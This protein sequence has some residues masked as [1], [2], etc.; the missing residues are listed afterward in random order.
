MKPQFEQRLAQYRFSLTQQQADAAVIFSLDN[1][2]YLFN[3]S[4]EAAY[5]VVTQ[6]ALYLITDYRFLEQAQE[7]CCLLELPTKVICRDRD[8]Q[9]LGQAIAEVLQQEQAK[10]VLYEA[11]HCTVAQW[12]AI[13]ADN[14]KTQFSPSQASLEQL[15][16]RKDA[17]E[18]AQIRQAAQ[19]ADA[20]L[21]SIMPLF[22]LGVSERDLAL[23]LD[24][25]MQKRG[26]HGVSFET[27]LGFGGRSALPHCIP[28]ERRLQQGDLVVLDF[29]AVVNGYRSDMTRSFVAGRAN[30]QQRAMYDTVTKA[31]QNALA[32]LRDGVAAQVVNAAS[33]SVLQASS[34]ASYAG[35]GLGHGVGIKLH[36]QPFISSVCQEHLFAGYVV[37]IEP[38][39]YIPQVGGVRIEDDV[40]ITQDG[41]EF[42]THAPKQFELEM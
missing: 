21:A 2:R 17:W 9:S 32:L 41:Y 25:Q 1:L 24:Y 18:V 36:E 6:Q 33:S 5:G 27:I 20:A 31:Q 11:E 16:K 28:S 37:T 14:S 15:R 30:E 3:Y 35:P 26:S 40:L 22:K 4:G 39:I 38:G 29:G 12:N 10:R 23:E 34:F 7:E 13:A 42:L 19:I 8:H